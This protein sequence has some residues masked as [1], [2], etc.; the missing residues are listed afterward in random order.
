M[1]RTQKLAT[2]RTSSRPQQLQS[3]F[4]A[5]VA[6]LKG[7]CASFAREWGRA[8]VAGRVRIRAFVRGGAGVRRR[9]VP[10]CAGHLAR[11]ADVIHARLPALA[12]IP[13]LQ[14]WC[15]VRRSG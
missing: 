5:P 1:P 13:L 14:S 10:H 2:L 4:L 12:V 8:L 11:A 9:P 7:L 6:G 3:S 15:W